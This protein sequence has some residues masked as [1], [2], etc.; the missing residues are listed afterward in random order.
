M[1]RLRYLSGGFSGIVE[2]G[3]DPGT[4]V[5]FNQTA[6]PTGWTK[7][8]LHD[9]KALRVVSGSATEG[10]SEAFSTVFGAGKTTESHTLST[11]QIPVHNHPY[12]RT[13]P[14][15]STLPSQPPRTQVNTAFNNSQTGAVGGNQGHTHNLNLDIQYVDVIIATK[16]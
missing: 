7:D 13:T 16:D 6:A 10:G 4:K 8:I 9:D 2:G 15:P 11:P 3:L 1:S 14:S 5:V 12:S